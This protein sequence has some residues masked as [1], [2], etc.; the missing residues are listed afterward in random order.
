M[1]RDFGQPSS[2]EPD[3]EHTCIREQHKYTHCTHL[4]VCTHNQMGVVCVTAY[5]DIYTVNDTTYTLNLAITG[6]EQPML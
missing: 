5:F 2:A 4:F 6:D 3:T 1:P